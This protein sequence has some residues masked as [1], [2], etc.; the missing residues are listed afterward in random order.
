[1]DTRS[2][3][4]SSFH[5]LVRTSNFNYIFYS[6]LDP[7]PLHCYRAVRQAIGYYSKPVGTFSF[8]TLRT[9]DMQAFVALHEC[10]I[11]AIN[12]FL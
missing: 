2:I 7:D 9:Q 1:M 8:V 5:K 3:S 11:S 10:Y 4:A 6:Y 12:D